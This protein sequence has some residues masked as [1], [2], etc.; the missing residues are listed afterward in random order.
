ML[1]ADVG[2]KCDDVTGKTSSPATTTLS[3]AP[4]GFVMSVT[5]RAAATLAQF[6]AN[7]VHEVV[8][9]VSHA[10]LNR[11]PLYPFSTGFNWGYGSRSPVMDGCALVDLSRMNRILNA[12]EISLDNPVAVIEP[13]VTQQQLYDFLQQRCPELTFNVTGAGRDTSII[14]NALDRGVGYTGPRKDDLYGLEVVTGTGE[15]LRT[16]FRRLGED[17]P[18]AHCHPFGLGPILDGLFF[19]GNFGIVTSACFRLYPRRPSEVA[20]SLAL[21]DAADLPLFINELA[22]L[23]REGLLTSVTHIGNRARTHSSMAYGITRYLENE[24]GFTPEAALIEADKALK[25]VAP[26]E[27]ASLASVTGNRGQVRAALFEIWRRTRK[28]ARLMIVTDG[29]LDLGYALTHRL[30]SIPFARANAAAISA[31]RPLHKLALGVPTDVA[32]ENLLWKF[33]HTSSRAAE[34]DQSRCGLLFVNP[35]LPLDGKVVAEVVDGMTA[36]AKQFDHILYMT[37]NVETPTSL[38]AVIN[39]LFDRSSGEEVARAHQC[40][41]ALLAFIHS[42]GL[43]VYRARADMMDK[44]V[45]NTPDYWKTVRELKQVFD[46]DNIIAPGRYNLP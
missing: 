22:R 41:D 1:N 25:L 43:E 28:F 4:S 30:R 15:V 16:G 34:L 26:N 3:I 2:S 18:L 27:W 33:G 39:L 11:T 5:S 46:P 24:C 20:V 6:Q 31:M 44:V 21:R 32:I 23:K 8:G 45:A 19:Q 10:R 17:S 35:A 29:I 13:G 14:G 12:D 9:L 40:A 42:R 7:S 37:L 38:V 36:V